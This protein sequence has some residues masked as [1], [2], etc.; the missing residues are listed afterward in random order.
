MHPS[1]EDRTQAAGLNV[2]NDRYSFSSAWGHSSSLGSPDLY[3]ANDFGRSNFYRSRGDGTFS[4][5]ATEAGVE[6]PGAGMSATWFDFDNDGNQD[7]YVGNM[8]SAAGIRISEQNIFQAK[9]PQEIR[10]LYRHHARGNSLYRNLGNGKFG[11]IGPQAGVEMGRWAWSSDAWDFDHDGYSD[12]YIANGYVSGTDSRDLSSFFWRQVVGES[13]QNTT[14]AV[15]YERGWNAINELIRSDFS[16]SGHERN[17][18][19]ANNHDG[20]FSE[21]SGTAGLDFP[22][23]SRAF[24]L[25][26]LDH[27]GRLEVILK[28]R[29]AP[30]LRVLRNAMTDLGHSVAF[31]L[32]GTKSNRDAIGAGVTV[33]PSAANSQSLRQ[34][35]YLQAGS[36]FLAQHSKDLFFGVGKDTTS[37]HATVYWPSGRTQ[38]FAHLP[39]NQRIEIEEGS[40]NFVVKP[41]V[42]E[43]RSYAHAGEPPRLDPLPL[44]IETWL[45]DPLRAPDFSLPDASGKSW[46][47]QS[48][49]G[50]FLFLNF[51]TSDS[52]VC[53]EQVRLLQ[54]RQSSL[55]S[56]GLH[57]AII[58]VDDGVSNE[59]S[60][61]SDALQSLV[62]KEKIP[63]PLLISTPDVA[64]M[65]NI[66]YRYLFDRRR[67]LAFPTSFLID[68]DGM[69]VK[70]YQG[71][72]D[73]KQVLQDLKSAPRTSTDRIRKALPMEGRLYRETFQRNDF[74]YGVAFFQHGYLDQAEASFKQVIASKPDDPEAHYNLGTLYLRR[75]SLA[76][77][78]QY[79]ERTVKLRPD[80]PEAWNNLGMLDAQQGH[81]DEAARNF[82][83]ALSLRPNYAVAIANLGNLY[84][85]QGDFANAEKLLNRALELEPD[86]AEVNYNLGMLYARQDQLDRAAQYLQRAT[87]LRPDYPD[88]LNNLG[89]LF[90]REQN[91]SAAED[92]FN[93]C[94]RV[95]PGFDQA[96]INLARVY[97]ILNDKEKARAI[98]QDLLHLQPQHKVAQQALEMLN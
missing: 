69:I 49:R 16:W 9:A 3:V 45:I 4:S 17:I 12:L 81:P 26:D 67:D 36:G 84:R 65:Y 75:N 71:P 94:I 20:S 56:A 11:N 61:G 24:A 87:V 25:A 42:A 1:F 2:D 83:Q 60:C 48:F 92:K 85:R 70:I 66:V 40:Q 74:T 72:V 28:N 80:Y 88:A 59:S 73:M 39:V 41:F 29:N 95:A 62:S 18:L 33:E 21:V 98:L 97:V 78:R 89:V 30:Q 51:S 82:Q 5:A 15:N 32:R 10:N 43:P 34:T 47:L 63:F 76:E 19:Y 8:W 50:N 79:L 13:P 23:D 91:Y 58:K 55:I 31:R 96:Y 7:I 38:T 77:A 27:D 54:Q 14:P 93:T 44:L 37:I 64:G 68:T 53:V 86:N 46:D 6:D 57:L 35:K 52:P 22:D 90:V